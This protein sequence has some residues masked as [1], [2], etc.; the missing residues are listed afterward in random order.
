MKWL[1]WGIVS[2]AILVLM[3]GGAVFSARH[4]FWRTPVAARDDPAAFLHALEA[5][6]IRGH[7][8]NAA[9]VLLENG[10]VSQELYV[11][12][13]RNETLGRDSIFQLASLSKWVSAWGVLDLAERGL[14]DLDAPVEK[15]LKR[16]SLPETA[17]DPSGVTARRLL[18]HTAGLDDGLGYD[19][20]TR[21]DERQ[22]L[23]QSL[24]LA[25]DAMKGAAGAVRVAWPPGAR[26]QYSGGGYTL[27]QLLVE[28]VG[29]QP[30]ATY[31]RDHILLPLGMDSSGYDL[32]ALP[33]DQIATVFDASGNP[34]K[35]RWFT[36]LAAASLYASAADMTLFLQAHLPETTGLH[37]PQAVLS[38]AAIRKLEN[39]QAF[40]FGVPV[41]G[42]GVTLFAPA[43]QGRFVFGHDG[44]N[45]PAI[46]T[47]ARLNPVSRDGLVVLS[48]G[49][50]GLAQR[51][52]AA[53][54]YWQT[55]RLDIAAL[56]QNLP[57]LLMRTCFIW[58]ILVIAALAVFYLQRIKGNE[59]DH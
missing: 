19:G 35:P 34:V 53:W 52:G 7:P 11:S 15:Y 30:F 59:A 22:S 17:F 58:L 47:T 36:A 4:G 27:L 55:G 40:K 51:I 48:S 33:S 1:V 21:K 2:A 25:A 45:I 50:A 49:D 29:N 18:S 41:W 32:G 44:V 6:F 42:L 43:G 12:S 28:D 13:D 38:R 39:P 26:W 8:G 10:A 3:L 37:S 46:S 57:S 20:F 14:I 5:D 31:M 24:T 9:V 54:T 23:P 16:W 56:S